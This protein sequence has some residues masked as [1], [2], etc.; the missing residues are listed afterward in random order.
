MPAVP[1]IHRLDAR[2]APVA[3]GLASALLL[4]AA[5]VFQA[6]GYVP[7]ELCIL[8]RWPHVAAA[9]FGLGVLAIGP[10]RWLLV[11]GLLSALAA[12]LIAGYHAGVEWGWW[13]GPSACTGSLGDLTALS[14]TDLMT[15]L[16]AAPVVRCD[17]PAL[18]V[19][20]L[21]MAGWNALASAGLS[22]LWAISLSR[23][24][25]RDPA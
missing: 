8:Q 1:V 20:G 15:R 3:A 17:Q 11:L 22:V 10:R 14:T 6:A 21:S 25:G 16:N 9:A 7:C 24:A 5:L 12:M 13:A 2:R 23:L 18:V 19:L 4:A